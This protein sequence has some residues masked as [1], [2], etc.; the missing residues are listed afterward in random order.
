M[1]KKKKAPPGKPGRKPETIQDK[2]PKK[3]DFNLPYLA[4]EYDDLTSAIFLVM[5]L[6]PL[7]PFGDQDDGHLMR[8]AQFVKGIALS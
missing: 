2:G 6:V 5:W 1:K 8:K 3:H 4:S 7:N